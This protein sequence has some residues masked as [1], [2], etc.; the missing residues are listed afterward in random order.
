MV[1]MFNGVQQSR[2]GVPASISEHAAFDGIEDLERQ[3]ISQV[4]RNIAVEISHFGQL[5]TSLVQRHGLVLIQV[6]NVIDIGRQMSKQE[7]L[8]FFD[9]FGNLD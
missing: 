5:G 1:N 6:T 4:R 9:F 3:S 8:V 7:A 2:I